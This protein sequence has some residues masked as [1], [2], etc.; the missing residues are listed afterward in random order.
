VQ[1]PAWRRELA[2]G[3]ASLHDLL[4]YL[5]WEESLIQ[6]QS[7]TD[8]GFRLRVPQG[9]AA[10]MAKG[11]PR[12]PLLRQVLPSP[13]EAVPVAGFGEDPVGDRSALRGTGVLHKYHGR[14]LVVT[15]GAC[16]IH[17]RYCFR[18]HFPY[19]DFGLRPAQWRELVLGLASDRSITE[20]I[21]S[22]GDP[23]MLDDQRLAAMAADLA[24]VPHLRRLRVHSRLVGL[25]PSRITPEFVHWLAGNRLRP[26][27]VLHFN[28]PRELDPKLAEVSTNSSATVS[29]C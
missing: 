9:Y 22:G 15:T 11:D 13:A 17:C 7:P 5:Q 19:A 24:R 20:V 21:L 8:Y 6:A 18:R 12:D 29:N 27:L 3:F 4:H 23:L 28:H 14:A 26:V 10:R 16:A 2:A 25:L 1:A